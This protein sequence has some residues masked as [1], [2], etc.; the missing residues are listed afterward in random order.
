MLESILQYALEN[1]ISDV[2]ITTDDYITFRSKKDIKKKGL[3]TV[4]FFI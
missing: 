1:K 2:H 4:P 3:I